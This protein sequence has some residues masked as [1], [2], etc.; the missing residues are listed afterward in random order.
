MGDWVAVVLDPRLT[1]NAC[2]V[3]LLVAGKGDGTHEVAHEDFAIVLNHA[4]EKTVR[5]ALKL[6]VHLGYLQRSPG[7]RGHSD[8][9]EF[10]VPKKAGLKDRVPKNGGLNTD[11]PAKNGG[12]SD[13]S[14]RRKEEVGGNP[15]PNPSPLA[16]FFDVV[17]A[18]DAPDNAGVSE[19]AEEA[20]GQHGEKLAGC[21]GALRDYL[22]QRVKPTR[23]APYV[24]SIA[25]WLN[26]LSP[27]VWKRPDGSAV[28]PEGRTAMLALA[29]NDL[30]A[31]DEEAMKR[32]AGDVANLK[33]KLSIIIR[34]EYDR[35]RADRGTAQG[36]GSRREAADH[37]GERGRRRF[38][39]EDADAA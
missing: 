39:G 16:R 10:R 14:S 34:Q 28:P 31:S 9:Y 23:Q 15:I 21:R 18:V 20:I 19:R 26:G 35:G 13:S 8:R 5:A 4:S 1:P 25:G 37:L 27:G 30:A 29:L 22:C 33:T 2:R 11:S 38:P 36:K 12:L 32:P 6:A 17:R 3:A 24:Q 7:G